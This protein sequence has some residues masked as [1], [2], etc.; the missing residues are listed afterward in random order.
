MAISLSVFALHRR[1]SGK[2]SHLCVFGKRLD[3]AYGLPNLIGK[4]LVLH[5]D[6]DVA[7]AV[8]RQQELDGGAFANARAMAG[9][10]S[11]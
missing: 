3:T 8:D 2:L 1:V 4:A 5:A 11:P 9:V 6:D 7:A 10:T